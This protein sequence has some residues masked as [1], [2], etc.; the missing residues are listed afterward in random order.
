MLQALGGTLLNAVPTF[1]LVVLLHFYLKSLFFK[2]LGKVLHERYEATAGARLAAEKSM[3]RAATR[4]PS[5]NPPCVLRA[6]RF[7]RPKRITPPVAGSAKPLKW[8]QPGN[9]GRTAQP[10]WRPASAP[11]WRLPKPT[12]SRERTAGQPDQRK[13]FSAGA[14][15]ELCGLPPCRYALPYVF[16]PP[17]RPPP[18]RGSG[19][20]ERAKVA[21]LAADGNLEMGEFPGA[22]RRLGYLIGKNAGP[23]FDSRSRQIRKDIV[24]ADDR[25][26]KAEARAAE[27]ERRLAS[28]EAEILALRTESQKEA[29]AET[30]A[31]WPARRRRKSPKSRATRNRKSPR[32]EKPPAWN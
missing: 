14:L 25:R 8:R 3:G 21:S 29:E 5:T 23:F 31:P 26:K 24:E 12:W 15:H 11:R 22:G 30:A 27:V 28:L 16:R 10:K 2:P 20:T 4:P 1:I 17:R 9:A 18:N 6:E 7:I 19:E 32:P 13:P